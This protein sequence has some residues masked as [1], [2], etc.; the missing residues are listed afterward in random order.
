MKQFFT[1]IVLFCYVFALC[2]PVTPA[3]QD[4]IAHTFFKFQHISTVH[5]E[6]GKYHLHAELAESA[7]DKKQ[8]PACNDTFLKDAISWYH[9]IPEKL[10]LSLPAA[11]TLIY[12]NVTYYIVK[13]AIIVLSQP[14]K[15]I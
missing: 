9:I 15:S 4:A 3:I 5:Y 8:S 1:H 14:P 2:K 13:E 6:D 10:Q 7:K 11:R 12:H